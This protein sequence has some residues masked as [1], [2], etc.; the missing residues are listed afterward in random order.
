MTELKTINE[1]KQIIL[2]A[3]DK[4]NEQVKIKEYQFICPVCREQFS[5]SLPNLKVRQGAGGYGDGYFHKCPYCNHDCE[6]GVS[7]PSNILHSDY[8]AWKYANS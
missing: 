3:R 5:F 4:I 8:I 1:Y 2:D 6:V 7:Y